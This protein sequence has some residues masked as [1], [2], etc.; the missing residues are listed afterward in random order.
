LS[1]E[2]IA[3]AAAAAAATP[4]EPEAPPATEVPRA[5]QDCPCGATPE[6]LVIEISEQNKVGRASCSACGTW[7]VEFLR[8]HTM[9]QEAIL[10]K[11][12]AAWDAAPRSTPP[13]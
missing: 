10:D 7:G 5:Y 2:T 12:H 6:R 9:E 3:E 8:G 4:V 13:A 11:A 1:E